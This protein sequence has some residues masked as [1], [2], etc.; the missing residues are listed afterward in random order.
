MKKPFCVLALL[1]LLPVL[2]SGQDIWN[3]IK[4]T[5]I[6]NL[7]GYKRAL[8]LDDSKRLQHWSAILGEGERQ[9]EV[10]VLQINAEACS[11][12]IRMNEATKELMLF[13]LDQTNKPGPMPTNEA[14]TIVLRGA[15]L[16]QVLILYSLFINRTVLQPSLLVAP[17]NLNV[18]ATN[19]MEAAIAL[20]KAMAEEQ[21][22]IVPDGNKFVLVVPTA[23]AKRATPGSSWINSPP[24]SAPVKEDKDL[25]EDVS[26]VRPGI[27]P[28][29]EV[30]FPWMDI[31]QV[32]EVYTQLIG[33]KLDRD[34]SVIPS[35]NITL[36]T[37]TPFSKEEAIYAFD[38]LFRLNGI[39]VIPAGKGMVKAVPFAAK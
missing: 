34:A 39:T 26:T 4:L 28:A 30:N 12:K 22:S 17:F 2:L 33:C 27:V 8:F 10:E 24:P 23:Q 5:G 6:A 21:L 11:V 3:N 9:E 7:P 20:E 15:S 1:S 38:T 32:L 31:H 13:G 25:G 29:G 37:R 18:P 35:V 14:G 19:R 16:D 36:R